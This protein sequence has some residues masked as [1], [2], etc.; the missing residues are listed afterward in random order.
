MNI[1]DY[2]YFEGSDPEPAYDPGF[3]ADCPF[4]NKRLTGPVKTTSFGVPGSTRSW[5]WRAHKDC[6]E[7]ASDQAVTEVDSFIIDFIEKPSLQ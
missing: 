5:F 6:Y 3:L 4:C 2:G 7:R 1:K